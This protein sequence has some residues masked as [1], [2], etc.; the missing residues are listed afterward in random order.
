MQILLIGSL[1]TEIKSHIHQLSTS[2]SI[3]FLILPSCGN[4]DVALKLQK[5][6]YQNVKMSI[7]SEL[8]CDV[9]LGD[10]FMKN[11]LQLSLSLKEKS[12]LLFYLD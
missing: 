8:V 5:R 11:I 1:A 4:T 10:E 12:H 2:S 3:C 6:T 7:V 9:I